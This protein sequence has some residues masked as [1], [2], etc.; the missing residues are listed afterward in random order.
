MIQDIHL[1]KANR[2]EVELI[3]HQHNLTFVTEHSTFHTLDV[4]VGGGVVLPYDLTTTV[5]HLTIQHGYG[6]MIV[7]DHVEMMSAAELNITNAVYSSEIYLTSPVRI[8]AI[9]N[10]YISSGK[11]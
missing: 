7:S 8:E 5:G 11:F 2:F 9:D 6:N 4:L 10:L 3:S 1:A